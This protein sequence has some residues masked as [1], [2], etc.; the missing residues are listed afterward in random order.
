MR[1]KG[2]NIILEVLE[3]KV[4]KNIFIN[5]K[6][7]TFFQNFDNFVEINED[8]LKRLCKTEE[9]E[10]DIEIFLTNLQDLKQGVKDCAD[11]YQNKI[12]RSI[13]KNVSDGLLFIDLQE[14]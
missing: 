8:F 14:S 11:I 4:S 9:N 13:L 3:D 6:N 10:Q 12:K 2:I 1:E 5:L 7:D